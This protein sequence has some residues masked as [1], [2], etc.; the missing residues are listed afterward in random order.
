MLSIF[1]RRG[2]L[3]RGKRLQLT[4]RTKAIFDKVESAAFFGAC[5]ILISMWL[6][7]NLAVVMRYFVQRPMGWTIETAEYSLVFICFLGAAWL[8]RRNKHVMLDIVLNRLN[9]KNQALINIITSIAGAIICLVIAW[10]SGEITW[11]LFQRGVRIWSLLE[12]PKAP[13]VMIV[14]V[15]TFLLFVEFLRRAYGYLESWRAL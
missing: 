5:A 12:P 6:S 3:L 2:N 7:I 9:L 14:P 10:Y 4:R 11:N 13:I 8:L 1:S 15:G